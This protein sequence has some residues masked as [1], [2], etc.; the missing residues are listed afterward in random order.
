VAE[1]ARFALL[2]RLGIQ[3]TVW[4]LVHEA[5]DAAI[6]A[7]EA[8]SPGAVTVLDAGCGRVSALRQFRPRIGRMVGADIHEPSTPLPYLDEFAVVDLCGSVDAF[9]SASF[10]VVLSNFT[11]EHFQEPATALANLRRWLRPGGTLVATT[12]N[13]RHPFVAAYLAMPDGPRRAVQPLVKAS[14]ADAHPLVGACNDP[15]TIRADLEAAGFTEI[16][17]HTVG[18]LAR[19]WGR[20]LPTFAVGL[21]GDLLANRTPSRRSTIVVVA[22]AGNDR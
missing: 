8:R 22:R 6:G 20:H 1:A 14:Q 9:P 19:A 16:R 2:P 11:L 13:R 18:H 12:V 7:A 5:L 21:A 17:L 15:A 4:D 10:D 3:P